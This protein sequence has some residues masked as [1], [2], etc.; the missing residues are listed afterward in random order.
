MDPGPL[1]TMPRSVVRCPHTDKV[2]MSSL[3]VQ[4]LT[5]VPGLL[6]VRTSV[7]VMY[8]AP[9]FCVQPLP[10]HV[11]MSAHHYSQYSH[12]TII[13]PPSNTW[14]IPQEFVQS[15]PLS[16]GR[17]EFRAFVDGKCISWSQ[18]FWTGSHLQFE[19]HKQ[20]RA[21]TQPWCQVQIIYSNHGKR[22]NEAKYSKST[23]ETKYV[24]IRLI[25]CFYHT[26]LCNDIEQRISMHN[27]P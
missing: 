3:G 18:C 8:Y 5:S 26:I 21:K 19:A 25:I 17:H 2:A 14:E 6:S 22:M 16:F 11:L 12:Y 15:L 27:T 20:I 13:S 24:E 7:Y 9:H 4:G 1:S 23:S 10:S